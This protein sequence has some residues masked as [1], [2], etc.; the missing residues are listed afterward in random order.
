MSKRNKI[1]LFIFSLGI[2]LGNIAQFREIY[3]WGYSYF[4]FS[5]SQHMSFGLEDQNVTLIN[6]NKIITEEEYLKRLEKDPNSMVIIDAREYGHDFNSKSFVFANSIH[7]FNNSEELFKILID[8]KEELKGKDLVVICH[9]GHRARAYQ[10]KINVFLS[11]NNIKKNIYAFQVSGM[12]RMYPRWK[13]KSIVY[14]PAT[15]I[16]S[17]KNQGIVQTYTI[18]QPP[19]SWETVKGELKDLDPHKPL[20]LLGDYTADQ[21]ETLIYP[22]PG[23]RYYPRK[24]WQNPPDWFGSMIMKLS[25][26]YSYETFVTIVLSLLFFLLMSLRL[27]ELYN[28]N[29]LYRY[30]RIFMTLGSFVFVFYFYNSFLITFS[31]IM[32]LE[33]SL[34]PLMMLFSI[35]IIYARILYREN[36]LPEILRTHSPIKFLRFIHFKRYLLLCFPAFYVG[37]YL[38]VNT[39]EPYLLLNKDCF[40]TFLLL[41]IH[42]PII[43]M[44]PMIHTILKKQYKPVNV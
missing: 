40:Y 26:T 30:L 11:K 6:E 22:L 14:V 3:I 15:M 35:A 1:L 5:E 37:A 2:V 16:P 44:I 12:L 38:S 43:D 10:N 31:Q 34:N 17:W 24:N 25:N 19:L 9:G 4:D 36:Y 23:K 20:V 39:S 32:T 29:T 13:T 8:K 18:P 21:I 33:E 7:H 28:D 27:L 42:V 41:I